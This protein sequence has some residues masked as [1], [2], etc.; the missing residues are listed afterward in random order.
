MRT[1][2]WTEAQIVSM[3]REHEAGNKAADL[4]RENGVS[5]PTFY[6]WKVKYGDLRSG[7]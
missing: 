7:T 1:S 3:L 4:C 2:K 5:Q 6:Q